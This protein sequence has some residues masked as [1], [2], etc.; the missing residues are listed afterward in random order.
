LFWSCRLQEIF[1][2]TVAALF[3]NYP[4]LKKE[5]LAIT[6]IDLKEHEHPMTAR[7][8]ADTPVYPVKIVVKKAD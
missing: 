4:T 1:D 6:A 2:A 3:E 5:D 8:R 7:Y